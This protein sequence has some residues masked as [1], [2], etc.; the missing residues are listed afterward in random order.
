VSGLVFSFVLGH[1]EGI[2]NRAGAL[3]SILAGIAVA[4]TLLAFGLAVVAFTA[5]GH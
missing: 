2:R 5:Y 4:V 3:W 1:D